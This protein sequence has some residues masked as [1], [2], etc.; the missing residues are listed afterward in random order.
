MSAE[1]VT[2]ADAASGAAKASQPLDEVMLAMDVVDTLRRRQ[3]LVER[4]L[5]AEGRE[6]DL[7]QRL[8]K[9]YAAQGIEVPDHV[10]DEGVAALKEERFVYKPPPHSLG[11]RLARAYVSRARWGKWVVGG[12]GVLLGAWL[13]Y[14][15]MV[16]APRNELP[17][18]LQ[19]AYQSVVEAAQ[20][21]EAESRAQELYISGRTALNDGDEDTARRLLESL[22]QLNTTL[23][24]VYTVRIVSRP[25][26][27]SGVWRVPEA[28]PDARN[29]Y[30]VVEAVAPDGSTLQV[31]ILNEE[32][33]RT[34]RVSK[35]ALRVDEEVFRRIAADKQDDGI[36]QQREFGAKRSGELH[37][38]YRI[39]TTGAAITDW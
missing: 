37:P 26:E 4:E 21:K 9:I 36:I 14:H 24:Q 22:S 23:Q 34:E 16:V 25:G 17:Q 27:M 20:D 5:D 10:L 35:W 6:Q 1:G 29:Y 31:P 33:G 11:T 15:I 3:R 13:L 2:T 7:R 19:A 18:R 38:D 32:T 12:F 28:N 8:R 39:P 30:I